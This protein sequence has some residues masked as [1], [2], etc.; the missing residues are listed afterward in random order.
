[1]RLHC[2]WEHSVSAPCMRLSAPLPHTESS[3]RSFM[4][5]RSGQ[6]PAVF[7]GFL[8]SVVGSLCCEQ[9]CLS[10]PTGCGAKGG[11]VK[12]LHLTFIVSKSNNYFDNVFFNYLLQL[13]C[14]TVLLLPLLPLQLRYYSYYYSCYCGVHQFLHL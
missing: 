8:W 13:I 7:L 5:G 4:P 2:A 9:G 11:E 14:A 3:I 10:D 1:M 12:L 6:F